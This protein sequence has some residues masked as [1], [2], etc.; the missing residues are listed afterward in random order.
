MLW[1][2]ADGSPTTA[3]EFL[4]YGSA[5]RTDTSKEFQRL[6]LACKRRDSGASS[7]FEG[8]L[9]IDEWRELYLRETSKRELAHLFD[10]PVPRGTEYGTLVVVS[11]LHYGPAEM[12]FRRW[13]DLRDWIAE[14][15]HVRWIGLG[16]YLDMALKTS[17]G[18]QNL[19]PYKVARTMFRDDIEPIAKQCLGLCHGNHEQR[20]ERATAVKENPVE[21]VARDLGLHY[22]GMDGFLRIKIHKPGTKQEQLY[23]GAVHHGWSSARTKGG[24]VNVAS[25]WLTWHDVDF[26]A[27][28]HMHANTSIEEQ[29]VGVEGQYV[30]Q[31]GVPLVLGGSFLKSQAGGY[32][33]EKGLHPAALGAGTLHLY[34]ARHAVHMRT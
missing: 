17:P 20:I 34:V 18:T 30:T 14:H 33:R 27:M 29:R 23:I 12:D 10:W 7:Q 24:Q 26:A 11:D 8:G 6:G 28:A 4:G 21:W 19:L 9:T 3:A 13:L 31:R 22:Y 5:G 25:N 32:V 15:P 2:F 16:D 1:L